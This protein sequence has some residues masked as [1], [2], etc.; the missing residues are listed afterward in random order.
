[1]IISIYVVYLNY[2]VSTVLYLIALQ[3]VSVNPFRLVDEINQ[4]IVYVFISNYFVYIYYLYQQ[5]CI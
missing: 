1:M 3:Q 4:V 2:Y 5:C